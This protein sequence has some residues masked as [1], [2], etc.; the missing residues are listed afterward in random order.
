MIAK[1]ALVLTTSLISWFSPSSFLP[2]DI[3][4]SEPFNM[5]VILSEASI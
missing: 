4:S 2:I 5:G 1:P 3:N